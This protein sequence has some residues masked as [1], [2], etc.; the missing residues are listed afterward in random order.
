VESSPE[1]KSSVGVL[2]HVEIF[3]RLISIDIRCW[4]FYFL[5]PI[6][7][8]F[9]TENAANR[10]YLLCVPQWLNSPCLL[11]VKGL[12]H[13]I[14]SRTDMDR[15]LTYCHDVDLHLRFHVFLLKP[16]IIDPALMFYLVSLRPLS[17]IQTHHRTGWN[18]QFCCSNRFSFNGHGHCQR[19]RLFSRLGSKDLTK[20]ELIL[21]SHGLYPVPSFC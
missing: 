2:S 9:V 3:P 5:A 16:L 10:H 13:F 20:C 15:W 11:V 14:V 21:S 17:L 4:L 19:P 1:K 6:N 12:Y 8:H 18:L 7:R